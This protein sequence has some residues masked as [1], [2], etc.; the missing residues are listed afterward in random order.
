M[1]DFW[2]PQNIP[3]VGVYVC[4][5]CPST[6]QKEPNNISFDDVWSLYAKKSKLASS[7]LRQW[8]QQQMKLD[9]PKIKE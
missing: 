8:V 4:H 6:Q 9:N 2:Y 1:A 3:L 5:E 7:M